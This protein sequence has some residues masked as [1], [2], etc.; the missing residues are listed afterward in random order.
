MQILIVRT[1]I[2]VG[3]FFYVVL[4]FLGAVLVRR[5]WRNF[6]ARLERAS[7]FP[8]LSYARAQHP[9]EGG[10]AHYRLLGRL[11]AVRG[12]SVV[13]V[14]KNQWSVAVDLADVPIFILPPRP[15]G[16]G[17]QSDPM[18]DQT[19]RV[20]R[21]GE[22]SALPEGTTLL[23]A[24]AVQQRRGEPTFV[25][26]PAFPLLVIV[27][28]CA[29]E[30]LLARAIWSGRQRN[31]YWNQLTPPSLAVGFL[32]E[33][34]IACVVAARFRVGALVAL[35]AALVPFLPL[36]PPGLAA[37]YLYRRLWQRGRRLRA[38]RDVL[39][40]P[41]RY[42]FD[43]HPHDETVWVALLPD[44]GVYERIRSSDAPTDPAIPVVIPADASE[45]VQRTWY[46]FRRQ[47]SE[48]SDAL[49]PTV[50]VAGEP[51]ERAW[52]AQ[53]KARLLELTAVATF[54]AGVLLNLN[55]ALR[56]LRE[57]LF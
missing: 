48:P 12:D 5:R 4:P 1:V 17:D 24:G 43:L 29:D 51:A 49:A 10:A 19:P 34:L 26:T 54:C 16:A 44:G 14:A 56:I 28:D 32:A 45:R 35:G 33:L 38:L 11:E 42:R 30:Q 7:L 52:R 22:L 6:R 27:Y 53:W 8:Q 36:L 3:V 18:P 40:M 23:V 13:Y 47:E 31:E 20:Y 39:R 9:D 41:L 50:A 25:S 57:I 37:F 15:V 46:L 55:I 2:V 21:W